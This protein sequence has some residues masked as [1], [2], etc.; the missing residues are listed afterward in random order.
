MPSNP[1]LDG[2]FRKI[3]VEAR[4]PTHLVVLTRPGYRATAEALSRPGGP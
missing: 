1:S 4:G 2:S 3:K